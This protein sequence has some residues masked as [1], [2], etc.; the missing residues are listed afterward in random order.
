MYSTSHLSGI[1]ISNLVLTFIFVTIKI[2]KV[3]RILLLSLVII[4][5]IKCKVE[6]KSDKLSEKMRPMEDYFLSKYFPDFSPDMDVINDAFRIAVSDYKQGI[7]TDGSWEVQGPANIGARI[8]TVAISPADDKIMLIGYSSGGMWKTIDGGVNWYPVFDDKAYTSIGSITFDPNNP[9]IVYAGSG[10][11]NVSGYPFVGDGLYKST[12][13]GETWTYSGLKETAIISRVVIPKSN[14]NIIYASAMGIPFYKS[15]NK[16]IYKSIDGGKNWTQSLFVNDSTGISEII[17]HPTNANIVY[18]VSW[19][20]IRNNSKSIVSGPD[21]KIYRTKNGGATWEIL[22]NGLPQGNFSR[23]GIAI[24]E[25]N[26]NVLYAQFTDGIGF[27]LHSIYKSTDGGDSWQLH[28]NANENGL[29]NSMGGFGWYFGKLR[30]N[31]DNEND[32]F[33]LGVYLMRYNPLA[34]T[35]EEVSPIDFDYPHADEHDMIFVNDYMYLATDGGLY[36]SKYIGDIDWIDIE[37]IPTTQFYRTGYNPFKPDSYYGGAQ[38]NGTSVGN[39]SSLNNWDRIWGGDGFQMLFNYLDSNVMYVETQNGRINVSQDGGQTF[40]GASEGLDG[41]RHWDMQYIMSSFD[42]QTLYTG[43]G[44]VYKSEGSVVPLWIPIS[45]ELV[46]YSVNAVRHQISTLNES[47]L[48]KNILYVG[49]TDAQVWNSLNGGLTWNKIIDGLPQRYVSSIKASPSIKNTVYVTLTGYRDNDNAGHIFKSID[50]GQNWEN[51]ASDL[52]PFAIN[53]VLIYPDGSDDILFVA[54]DG[55][56]YVTTNGGDNWER[57][58]NNMPFIPVYDL[59]Y[60]I[61]NNQLIAATFARSLQTFD[62]IQIGISLETDVVENAKID[63]KVFPSVTCDVVNIEGEA[64]KIDVLD[65][66]GRIVIK[67]NKSKQVSLEGMPNGIYYFRSRFG[68]EKV[69][70]I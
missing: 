8:N 70:K 56:I 39:K 33:L 68:T 40:Q 50:N 9:N 49:T 60:N 52:P 7:R 17:L 29:Q 15:Q 69:V 24:A 63:W 37:N 13:G 35:W 19:N 36:K 30:V 43:T 6:V 38:D 41:N 65:G 64:P 28:T 42:P 18:A 66:N 61:H 62:L 45:D 53:D 27:D 31:P 23:M 16:G 54:T 25:S 4:S 46:D 57:L 51:I 3:K 14:S 10:D 2:V 47:P 26:P 20:R 32:L 34:N 5:F 59:E 58:G 48:D 44:K 22:E 55:G 11:P 21:A 67:G 12:N 1:L